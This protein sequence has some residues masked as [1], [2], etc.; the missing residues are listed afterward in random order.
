[1]VNLSEGIQTN[2]WSKEMSIFEKVKEEQKRAVA[3]VAELRET[4]NRKA[5]LSCMTRKE[6][7][8][9]IRCPVC[10]GLTD[11]IIWGVCKKCKENQIPCPLCNKPITF[12]H[13]SSPASCQSCRNVIVCANSNCKAPIHILDKICPHCGTKQPSGLL[14]LAKGFGYLVLALGGALILFTLF[15]GCTSAVFRF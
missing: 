10:G 7:G 15:R 11:E 14:S 5:R 1:M 4:I 3:E 9:D 12:G 8:E 2:Q 6:M 13:D